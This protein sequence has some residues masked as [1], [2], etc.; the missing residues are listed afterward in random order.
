MKTV[1]FILFCCIAIQCYAQQPSPSAVIITEHGDTITMSTPKERTMRINGTT[2][3]TLLSERRP[4]LLN[5]RI[6]YYFGDDTSIHKTKHDAAYYD[7]MNN[8]YNRVKNMLDNA[9]A[10]V[11]KQ[12]PDGDY[13]V[14]II[15]MV[16]NE[17]GKIVYYEVGDVK[18][19]I[20]TNHPLS[21]YSTQQTPEIQSSI[22]RQIVSTTIK[23]IQ[24]VPYVRENA[25]TPY[26]THF[27]YSFH[28]KWGKD[29]T[30]GQ[31]PGFLF[32]K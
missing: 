3:T 19:H 14:D 26:V 11:R 31:R 23:D 2:T 16:V 24:Y 25:P 18:K 22:I 6:I 27:I 30:T 28:Q 4:H 12:L 13:I 7:S 10:M 15:N 9:T 5:N 1:Q 21:Q 17:Q 32:V 29:D 20:K 8:T